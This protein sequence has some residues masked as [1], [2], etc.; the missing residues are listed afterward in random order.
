VSP[1]LDG[2]G[3]VLGVL[4]SFYIHNSVLV[5]SVADAVELYGG[6]LVFYLVQQGDQF[7]DG[8]GVLHSVYLL[9][10]WGLSLSLCVFII[11]LRELFVKLFFTILHTF[12][13]T[14]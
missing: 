13:S 8:H 1:L 10:S 9:Y 12:F 4:A 5:G 7:S 11:A 2:D 3:G 14:A 6:V